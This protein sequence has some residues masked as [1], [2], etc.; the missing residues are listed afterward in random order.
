MD[1]FTVFN[2]IYWII[3]MILFGPIM[4][5][6]SVYLPELPVRYVKSMRQYT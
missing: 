2:I 1:A 6:I 5:F 4:F 3:C